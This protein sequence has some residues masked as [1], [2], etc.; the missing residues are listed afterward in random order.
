MDKAL[1]GIRVIDMTHNQAGPAC[2]QMLAFLGADVIKLE[3]PKAGDVARTVHADIK[4]S[5]SLFFLLFNANKKSLTLNLKTD[6]GKRLFKQVIGQSDVLIENFGPGAMERLGLGWDVLKELNPRLIYATIKGFGSYGPLA[7]FKSYEPVA[8][9]M[10]GAMSITGFP[11]NPPTLVLPAIGDS[12]TGMQMAIGILAALQQRHST[13]RG[14]HVEVSMQDAVVNIIRVSLRDHQRQGKPMER[15]GNQLGHTVPGTTYPCAPGGS[16]DHV[17]IFCQQQ[18]WKAFCGAMG[19]PALADDPR[20]ATA[21]ARWDNRAVL[22]PIIEAWTRSHTKHAIMKIL[23]DAGVPCGACQDTGE[24]LADPHLK[25]REMIVDI[26]YPTR[27][28]YQ[29]VGCPVKMSDS[30]AAITRPPLLGEHTE[31]LLSELCGVDPDQLTRLRESGA[32]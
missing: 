18:M 29:T 11:E 22:E 2:A 21:G 23:G 15:H 31:A 28:T 14:Q 20:F 24:V 3:E 6:E 19:Q 25:A 32:I 10:G 16:N 4:G 12:G 30:P 13:G 26:D 5:D 27:G 9:A 1:S 7:H 17:L 8:Q